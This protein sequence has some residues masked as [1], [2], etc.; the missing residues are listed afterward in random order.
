[1]KNCILVHNN[2]RKPFIVRIIFPGEGCGRW[3]EDEQEWAMTNDHNEPVLAFFDPLFNETPYGY[4]TGAS[5]FMSTLLER[6]KNDGLLLD[7]GNPDWSLDAATMEKIRAWASQVT[8]P[9]KERNL[10]AV[11]GRVYGD[12]DDSLFLVEAATSEK[13][14]DAARDMLR[15]ERGISADVE[16]FMTNDRLVATEYG[17]TP[18]FAITR[19]PFAGFPAETQVDRT[20]PRDRG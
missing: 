12:D 18:E 19:S 8:D 13:A 15:D 20:T 1:M 11:T 2:A 5:Y 9:A 7:G 10:F 17:H 4:F 14:N 3:K 16:T 6:Q